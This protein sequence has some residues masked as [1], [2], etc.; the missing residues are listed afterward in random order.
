VV[1]AGHVARIGWVERSG[2]GEPAQHPSTH[3]LLLR[4]EVFGR[5]RSGLVAGLEPIRI[6]VPENEIC[7]SQSSWI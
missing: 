5:Q 4:G 2:A 7:P 6:E 1:P 3:L